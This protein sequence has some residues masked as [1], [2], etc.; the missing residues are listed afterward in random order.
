VSLYI[1]SVSWCIHSVVTSDASDSL[2]FLQILASVMLHGNVQ[3][4]LTLTCNSVAR[5]QE[6]VNDLDHHVSIFGTH[7]LN[8]TEFNFDYRYKA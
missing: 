5:I 6:N 1:A 3:I 4:P 7:S 8:D 2:W